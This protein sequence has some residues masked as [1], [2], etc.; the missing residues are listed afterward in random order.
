MLSRLTFTFKTGGKCNF[1]CQFGLFCDLVKHTEGDDHFSTLCVWPVG[2]CTSYVLWL[3]TYAAVNKNAVCS[4][5][6]VYVPPI[7]S[8]F[9]TTTDTLVNGL[10]SRE[11]TNHTNH[12]N[13]DSFYLNGSEKMPMF[14]F[15]Q[16]RTRV[17][18]HLWAS[19]K[20]TDTN[21]RVILFACVTT[22]RCLNLQRL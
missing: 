15:Y 20:I 10:R 13:L 5:G 6:R 17:S 11:I 14:K 3:K 16:E 18:Y 19:G 7:H 9:I 8:H 1:L 12:T 2:K 4:R 22:Q 21:M